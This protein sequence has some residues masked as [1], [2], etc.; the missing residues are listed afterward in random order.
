MTMSSTPLTP[1]TD[2]LVALFANIEACGVR[3]VHKPGTDEGQHLAALMKLIRRHW[4]FI[5]DAEMSRIRQAVEQAVRQAW[6][7]YD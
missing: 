4:P 1:T 6:E 3:I 2:G 7:P 5:A